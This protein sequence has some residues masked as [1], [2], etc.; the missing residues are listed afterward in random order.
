MTETEVMPSVGLADRMKRYEHVSRHLLMRRTPVIIRLDGR[1]F[2]TFCHGLEQPFDS[3]F[4]DAM[5]LAARDTGDEM[6][7][8]KACY[9]QSDEA[10]FLL[11]DYDDVKTEP[12]FGYVL[13]KVASISAATMTARFNTRWAHLLPA[14]DVSKAVFDARAFNVPHDEVANYFLW[15]MRDWARNSLSMYAGSCFWPKEIHGKGR[16][17]INHNLQAKWNKRANPQIPVRTGGG[18]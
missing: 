16:S 4:I 11:T 3:D 7:G 2:H 14:T 18:C 12:W 10:S 9:I 1:A 13:Q 8:F 6:Q 15:R 17:E 5:H